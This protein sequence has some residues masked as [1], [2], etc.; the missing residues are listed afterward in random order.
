[1]NA[2]EAMAATFASN[3]ENLSDEQLK[4]AA[5]TLCSFTQFKMYS[6]Q[7]IPARYLIME[8]E[9]KHL[10]ALCYE[11]KSTGRILLDR[12]GK[13]ACISG[14]RPALWSIWPNLHGPWKEEP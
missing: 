4:E 12:D 2:A 5:D 1:M 3:L 13:P 8:E 14:R 6:L 11:L 10:V 7:H 9:Q